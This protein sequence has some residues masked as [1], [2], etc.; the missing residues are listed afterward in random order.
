MSGAR[1]AAPRPVSPLVKIAGPALGAALALTILVLLIFGDRLMGGGGSG[2][3]GDQD[4]AKSGTEISATAVDPATRDEVVEAASAVLNRWSQPD[5]RYDKWW[6]NLKPLLTPGGREA[7]AYTDPK[8]VP[9]LADM[10]ADHVVLNPSG[11]TAT[12][13]FETSDGIFGVDL[14]RK[15]A[16]GRWLAN[17][18]V[19][20]GE[21]SMFA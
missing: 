21:E 5:A 16:T 13:W 14:S 3:V 2:D 18:V 20:P 11:A 9:E 1:K 19:F 7:Y 10:T 15:D 4:S 8:Q 12:V 17:R 6:R